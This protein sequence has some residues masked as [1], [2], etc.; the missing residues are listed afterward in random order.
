MLHIYCSVPF[1]DVDFVP[2]HLQFIAARVAPVVKTDFCT[3]PIDICPVL[4]F[5]DT[6]SEWIISSGLRIEPGCGELG[7]IW[8][9]L[10]M[11]QREV[12]RPHLR[13]N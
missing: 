13:L 10:A 1:S 4:S 2:F 12:F 8:S 5:S 3:R 9:C 6:P 11:S 7:D